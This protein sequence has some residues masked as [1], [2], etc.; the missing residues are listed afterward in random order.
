[1]SWNDKIA[2]RLQDALQ[3]HPFLVTHHFD[4]CFLWQSEQYTGLLPFDDALST[5]RPYQ[6]GFVSS[7]AKMM[8]FHNP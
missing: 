6:S 5:A 1:M 8:L 3:D 7:P 2:A 4:V